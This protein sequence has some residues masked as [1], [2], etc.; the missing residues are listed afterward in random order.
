MKEGTF[1]KKVFICFCVWLVPI[2]TGAAAAGIGVMEPV[3]GN[4]C[5]ITR[6]R[7]DLRFSLTYV[8]RLLIMFAT[9]YIYAY[10]WRYLGRRLRPSA[11]TPDLLQRTDASVDT[12][13]AVPPRQTTEYSVTIWRK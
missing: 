2:A 9:I 13:A 1:L 12:S 11:K 3:S 10:I 5:W 7:P 4:W 6:D 8:W